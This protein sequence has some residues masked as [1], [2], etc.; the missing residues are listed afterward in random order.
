MI[1]IPLELPAPLRARIADFQ[2][3]LSLGLARRQ[4]ESRNHRQ[5][6]AALLAEEARLRS[7]LAAIEAKA[8]A[9]CSEIAPSALPAAIEISNLRIQLEIICRRL[10]LLEDLASPGGDDINLREAGEI[11][12]EIVEFY[13]HNLVPLIALE[14]SPLCSQNHQAVVMA[15]MAE[16]VLILPQ[17]RARARALWQTPATPANL[18]WLNQIFHRALRGQLHLGFD[19]QKEAAQ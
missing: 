18:R 9:L 5:E 11:L 3:S 8:H 16:C 17:L 4:A 12:D 7:H 6:R 19:A 2:Q 10:E 13:V 1:Q 15:R 14:L